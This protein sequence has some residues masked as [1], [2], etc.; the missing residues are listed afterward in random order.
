MSSVQSTLFLFTLHISFVVSQT[1][2]S[3][4]NFIGN[5]MN[6]YNNKYIWCKN[7]FNDESNGIEDVNKFSYK[8]IQSL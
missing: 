4:T 1:L 3:L 7:I 8:L 5:N 6:I 2:L